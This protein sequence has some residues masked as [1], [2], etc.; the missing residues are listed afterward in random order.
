MQLASHHDK[1]NNFRFVFRLPCVPRYKLIKEGIIVKLKRKDV[2]KEKIM[3]NKLASLVMS[4]LVILIFPILELMGLEPLYNC[5]LIK[6]QSS[7]LFFINYPSTNCS[8]LAR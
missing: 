7:G 6:K 8:A 5:K 4:H 2:L 3:N 1:Q